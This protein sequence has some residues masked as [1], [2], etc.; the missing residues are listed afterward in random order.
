MVC[1]TS[2]AQ[3]AETIISRKAR[4]R[5]LVLLAICRSVFVYFVDQFFSSG[6]LTQTTQDDTF[7]AINTR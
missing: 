1:G 2:S 6:S 5:L 4:S 3:Q 7:R